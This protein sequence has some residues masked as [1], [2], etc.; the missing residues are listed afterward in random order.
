[1]YFE[2]CYNLWFLIFI[3]PAF[4]LFLAR[5][6]LKLY[7]NLPTVKARYLGFSLFILSLVLLVFGLADPY[8]IKTNYPYKDLRLFFLLDISKSMAYAEDIKPNR[9]KAAKD[10]IKNA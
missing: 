6:Q 1:M 9:L 8:I 5:K 10:E 7:G 3:I 4:W 2:S